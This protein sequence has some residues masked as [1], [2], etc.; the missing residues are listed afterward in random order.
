MYGLKLEN[1]LVRVRGRVRITFSFESTGTEPVPVP[2]LRGLT[3]THFLNFELLC[4]K[5][6]A[7]VYICAFD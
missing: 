2:V 3:Y 1:L 6:S 4:I 7:P 5:K